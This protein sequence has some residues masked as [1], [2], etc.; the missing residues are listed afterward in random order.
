M[1]ILNAIAHS[2]KVYEAALAGGVVDIFDD[3]SLSVYNEIKEYYNTDPDAQHVD[4]D[5][6]LSR[7]Q[8]RFPKHQA[9]FTAVVEQLREPVSVPN[10]LVEI[11]AKR[12]EDAKDK[13][14]TACTLPGN[15][16]RILNL[17]EEY[18]SY[19]REDE[20]GTE[21]AT[22]FSDV[23]VDDILASRNNENTIA[24]APNAL[25]NAAG[26]SCL[27]KHHLLFFARP[28]AGKTTVAI[29]LT[30]GFLH[31]GLKVLYIGNEDPPADIIL[32]MMTRIT[33][34][35][36]TELKEE[37]ARAQRLLTERNWDKF[38]F[39]E[40]T[41]G[42]RSELESLMDE[43]RPDVLIVDQ[44]RNINMGKLSDNRVL[45]LEQ[46]EQFI[47]NL[48]KQ[49]NALTISFT[50]AGASAEGKLVL[51]LTDVD[52][53][54][55]GMAASADLMVGIG[56]NTEYMQTGRRIMTCMKNKLSGGHKEPFEIRIDHRYNRVYG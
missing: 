27:R 8:K 12:K 29:T 35:Q 23:T 44:S 18:K 24:L 51:E 25:N 48:G 55:T 49:Y 26:K 50:Q 10:I 34:M 4:V 53:S 1:D 30:A 41:P 40:V 2:R 47:R 16:E 14:A 46:V 17:I 42:T 43:H 38:I 19:V 21:T 13:L 28:D 56:V 9:V 31:Q 22:V 52:Y 11:N 32:R 36:E 5:I 7:V 15:D 6:I 45:Q 39:V 3:R 33:Q 54:N 20:I 37:S